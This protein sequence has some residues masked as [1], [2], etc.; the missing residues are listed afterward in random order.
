MFDCGSVLVRKN[1]ECDCVVFKFANTK[2][3]MQLG[4]DHNSICV[5]CSQCCRD[6]DSKADER[7]GGNVFSLTP[8]SNRQ[9]STRMGSC[10]LKAFTGTQTWYRHT[11]THTSTVYNLSLENFPDS[12]THTDT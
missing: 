2:K 3:S 5:A 1:G 6:W 8:A 11:R 12:L 10:T 9:P 4:V 7:D